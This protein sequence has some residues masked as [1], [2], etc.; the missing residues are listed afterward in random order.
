MATDTLVEAFKAA[1]RCHAASVNII[2]TEASGTRF[3]M[4]A[5]AV[6]SLGIAP[7]SLLVCIGEQASIAPALVEGR[8]FAVNILGAEHAW[9]IASFSGAV[10]NEARFN[11]GQWECHS[12]GTPLLVGA[13][14]TLLCT[15][16]RIV[17][18]SGHHIVIGHVDEVTVAEAD[19]P[20]VYHNRGFSRLA[21]TTLEAAHG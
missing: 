16:V 5:T 7:P 11:S 1:M 4:A 10:K 12:R 13:Q 8:A 18:H 19:M 2:T 15:V 3:G 20:L 9:M 14:A 17:V 6:C 21:P